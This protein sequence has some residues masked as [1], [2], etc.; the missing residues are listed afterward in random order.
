MLCGR[1]VVIWCKY[2]KKAEAVA[3]TFVDGGSLQGMV[4]VLWGWWLFVWMVVVCVG[5][6]VV[7][8]F[9]KVLVYKDLWN[10]G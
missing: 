2:T 8:V 1:N 4:V 3:S 6:V 5:M 7:C 9:L 10:Y